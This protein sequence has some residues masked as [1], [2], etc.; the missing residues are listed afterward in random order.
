MRSTT[1]ATVKEKTAPSSER[2]AWRLRGWS[3]LTEFGTLLAFLVLCLALALLSPAFL[4]LNNFLTILRQVSI[5]AIISLGM[6]LVM[7]TGGI[8]LS[9][10][11]AA[12]A[13]ALI[14]ISLLSAGLGTLPAVLGGLTG[15]L[16]LGAL[17]G[18]LVGFLGVMPFLATLGTHTMAMSMEM[19]YTQGGLPIYPLGRLPESFNF[20]GR[21]W[22]GPV[23]FP[24]L[25]LGGIL[26]LYYLI[27]HRSAFGRRV[28]AV[29]G[30]A[31]AARFSGIDVRL[32]R[33]KSYLLAGLTAALAGVIL[34]S[35]ISSGQPLAGESFL[36]DSIA[37]S[38]M[39]MTLSREGKPGVLG[40]LFGAC[41]L[42]V[43]LNGMTL[44]NVVFYLQTL[45][46]GGLL[47]GVLA[48]ASYAR[49][50]RN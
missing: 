9:V 43:V 23:P 6:T 30:N 22:V 24:V 40:T 38:F 10:G 7:T 18:L 49:T 44:L 5:L 20:L 8:D 14:S 37:A 35:R 33:F 29:G 2:T 34:A 36:L 4:T 50:K 31:E 39:G 46:K 11:E 42:G 3:F 26:A 19:V 17:N 27:M 25:I 21:G 48:L 1:T 16:L 47:L 28:Y 41:F 12:D 13:G 15:G 32:V 45:I